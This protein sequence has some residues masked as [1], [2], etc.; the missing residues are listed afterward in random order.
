MCRRFMS[1]NILMQ[2]LFLK[3]M[4][5]MFYLPMHSSSSCPSMNPSSH[6]HSKL[7]GKL[8]HNWAHPPL[9]MAHSSASILFQKNLKKN[10]T[11]KDKHHHLQYIITK[12]LFKKNRT[13]KQKHDKQQSN[14][15]FSKFKQPKDKTYM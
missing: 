6:L 10:R 3:P 12:E 2:L 15:Y 7:P 9:S 13:N 14:W 8:T 5:A 4:P 1:D 11:N